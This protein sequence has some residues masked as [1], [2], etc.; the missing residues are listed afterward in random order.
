[1]DDRVKQFIEDNIELIED[2]Q[3]EELYT[4]TKYE[5]DIATGEFTSCMFAIDIHPEVY[6]KELPARFLFK[7]NIKEFN[8]PNNI[9]SIGMGAF[10]GCK[11]LTCV[12]IP[13]GVT[14]IGIGVFRDCSKLTSMIIP[15]S[16]T[17]ISDYMF[18]DGPHEL[19]I[20][21]SGTKAD[22]KKIYNKRA[23][24]DTYFTINCTDGKILKKKR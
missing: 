24:Q 2:N 12:T 16:V 23:F 21:Y 8:I 15:K 6:L 3:W 22:W 5:L 13:N 18:W 9:T 11:N 10:Y 1:M 17:A 19:I 7:S 14:S 4:K 20:D